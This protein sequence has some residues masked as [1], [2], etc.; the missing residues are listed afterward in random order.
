M[1][2]L[3]IGTRDSGKSALAEDLCQQTGDAR[4]Y[5][6]AT[7]EVLDDAG[8]ERVRKHL[9]KRRGKGFVTIERTH[10]I[11][12][13]LADMQ[14]KE[15]AT[16]LLE[17]VANLVGNEMHGTDPERQALLRDKVNGPARFADAVASDIARLGAGVHHLI[18]VTDVFPAEDAGYDEETRLYVRLLELVNERLIRMADRVTD[19]R[20]R[21]RE[22]RGET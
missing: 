13:A 1:M 6:L 22:K 10:G 16:V 3:V 17:C 8:R 12:G 9:E 11:A 5:Y 20:E 2:T 21:A 19:V 14:D 4:R 7:M 15:H 18:A